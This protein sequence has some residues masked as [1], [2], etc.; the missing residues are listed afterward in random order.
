MSRNP[1]NPSAD[2]SVGL[3]FP[4]PELETP[5]I[6]ALTKQIIQRGEDFRR[7]AIRETDW[8]ETAVLRVIE[9]HTE[10]PLVS[11]PEDLSTFKLSGPQLEAERYDRRAPPVSAHANGTHRCSIETITKPLLDRL[12]D[13]HPDVLDFLDG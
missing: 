1:T 11:D 2:L 7:Q 9:H 4:E 10:L 3:L 5:G 8:S 6:D 12:R 13:E